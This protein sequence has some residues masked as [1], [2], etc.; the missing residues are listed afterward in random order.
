M[1]DIN[2]LSD[3]DVSKLMIIVGTTDL[4]VSAVLYET[5]ESLASTD[6]SQSDQAE[7]IES[8]GKMIQDIHGRLELFFR[9]PGPIH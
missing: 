9:S 4:F 5:L 2:K 1:V 3:K 8:L 7:A 6:L